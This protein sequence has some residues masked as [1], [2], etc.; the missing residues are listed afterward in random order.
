[1]TQT[2]QIRSIGDALDHAGFRSL[3]AK[4]KALGLPRSTT[5][6]ILQGSH[7]TSGLSAATVQR[8]L[9]SPQLPAAARA[10]ILAYVEAKTAG[11]FGRAHRRWRA[12]ARRVRPR[13]V[14]MIERR[15]MVIW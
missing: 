6:T 12:G 9:A 15:L 11:T 2:D 5:W 3:D 8:M 7:K 10:A 1:V 4:A 14:W 13:A